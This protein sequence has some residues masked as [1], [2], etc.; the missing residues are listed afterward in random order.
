MHPL[1][2][3][4]PA[5]ALDSLRTLFAYTVPAAPSASSYTSSCSLSPILP[6]GRTENP[7][8]LNCPSL[9]AP[10]T[11]RSFLFLP[12]SARPQ[13]PPSFRLPLPCSV[14]FFSF[15]PPYFVC[16]LKRSRLFSVRPLPNL[17]THKKIVSSFPFFTFPL[18]S[19]LFTCSS[20]P[21]G[22]SPVLPLLFAAPPF[23]LLPCWSP[24]LT[25]LASHPTFI[26][27]FFYFLESEIQIVYRFVCPGCSWNICLAPSPSRI[28]S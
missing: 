15:F 3:C 23:P 13:L 5:T 6:P 16:Q 28:P 26:E 21:G 25:S 11:L 17:Y 10:L 4:R 1:S 20:W 2:H 9:I 14:P 12:P 7:C 18:L 22:D 24:P 8:L 27:S 19:F